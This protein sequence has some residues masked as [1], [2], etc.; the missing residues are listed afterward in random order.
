MH[1]KNKRCM[2][3]KKDGSLTKKMHVSTETCMLKRNM[4]DA[5]NYLMARF[6]TQV[7]ILTNSNTNIHFGARS[8]ACRE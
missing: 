4:L 5:I 2:A 8:Q 6:V 7:V 1:D 3:Q